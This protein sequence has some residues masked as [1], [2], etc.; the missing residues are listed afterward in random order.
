MN[1]SPLLNLLFPLSL[2]F[3]LPSSAAGAGGILT[4][5]S[6]CFNVSLLLLSISMEDQSHELWLRHTWGRI[7]VGSSA[8]L[9]HHKDCILHNR[10]SFEWD[11]GQDGTNHNRPGMGSPG[12]PSLWSYEAHGP[13]GES[14]GTEAGIRLRDRP[15]AREG[16]RLM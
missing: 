15:G 13:C 9:A 14:R 1:L 6:Y 16:K 12:L 2:S 5:L 8:A 11:W 4:G 3:P 10:Q 7:S